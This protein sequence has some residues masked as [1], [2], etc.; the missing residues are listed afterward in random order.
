[1]LRSAL[2]LISLGS[3]AILC[4][5]SLLSYEVSGPESLEA[6]AL[7]VG[8]PTRFASPSSL[9]PFDAPPPPRLRVRPDDIVSFVRDVY[10]RVANPSNEE[11]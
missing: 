9:S 11:I 7:G 6:P 1:L 2:S 5:F 3:K 10:S 4:P 8:V